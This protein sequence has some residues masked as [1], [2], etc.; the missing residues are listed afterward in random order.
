MKKFYKLT[1]SCFCVIPLLLISIFSTAGSLGQD[2]KAMKVAD[3]AVVAMGGRENYDNTRYLSWVFFGSRFHIWDKYTGDIRIEYNKQNLILMNIHTKKGRVWEDGTE[4]VNSKLL[5]EKMQWGYETW[6]N[7]SY[8]LVMPYKLHDD[9]VN[10]VYTRQDKSLEGRPVDVLTMTFEGVGVTPDN[11]YEVFF[12]QETKL[13]SEF[14]YYPTFET[15]IPRFRL[16]WKDWKMYDKIK[17][18]GSRGEKGMAPINVFMS[19][20]KSVLTENTPAKDTQGD[21]ITGAMLQ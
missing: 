16:P 21:M 11:K 14:A 1:L 19:L 6:I 7:D 2:A 5:A 17:L 3:A 13:L 12:D 8:W 15:K 10:L 9:G 20:P 18:S 4:I